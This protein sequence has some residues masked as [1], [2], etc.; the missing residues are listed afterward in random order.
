MATNLQPMSKPA[1]VRKRR[2]YAAR[3]PQDVR[4]QQ[5]LDAALRIIARD[6]YAGVTME[7]VAAEAGVTKPVVYGVYPKLPELLGDLLDRT[8][9]TA[10]T[11]LLGAFPADGSTRREDLSREV[12]LAWMR[13]V[14][15]HPETWAPILVAEANTPAVVLARIEQGREAVRSAVASVLA[16]ATTGA[17]PRHRLLAEAL[18]ATAEH[19]GRR[20]LVEPDGVD[21]GAV[22]DLIDDLIQ[23]AFKG[24]ARA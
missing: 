15:D 7:A 4:R 18:I 1:E 14:R 22:A 8:Q 23:G 20:L 13:T 19:F 12:T 11:Q 24:G 3:V 16:E 17:T 6:G 21:D 9:G 2:A 10:L 5:L